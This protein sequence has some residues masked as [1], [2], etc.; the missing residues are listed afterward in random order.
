MAIRI[1]AP[2]N[3]FVQF[4][5]V[6]TI[7]SCEFDPFS[8]CLPVFADND[9][10]FQFIIETDTQ[11]EADSLCDLGNELMSIGIANHCGEATILD[12]EQKPDRYRI[13]A[14]HLLYNWMH[15]LPNFATVISNSECFLIKITVQGVY[16]VYDFCSNCFQRIAEVCHTS[17]IEYSNED[18]AY[19]F[20]YCGGSII[21]SGS[22]E[23]CEPLF[24]QFTNQANISIP[25][26]TILQNKYGA[27]PSVQAWIFDDNNELVDM[28]IR[29]SFDAFPPTTINIDFGGFSSGIIKIS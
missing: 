28:G 4:D 22:S 7:D 24:I 14:T 17:V 8:I 29:A 10:Y 1:K 18:N 23:S 21:D 20:D 12:F 27:V 5:E 13:D 25:Y 15:G 19:G 16:T 26:T 2:V 9:V 3:S 11:D 6:D